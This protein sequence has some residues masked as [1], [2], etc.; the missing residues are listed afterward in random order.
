MA[1]PIE[2][3]R[4][5]CDR[6][7]NSPQAGFKAATHCALAFRATKV[8][9]S[10]RVRI[11]SGL[12]VRGHQ[13]GNPRKCDH[14][15]LQSDDKHHDDGDELTL[16]GEKL[17]RLKASRQTIGQSMCGIR[18][19]RLQSESRWRRATAYWQSVQWMER[20]VVGRLLT[21]SHF[22]SCHSIAHLSGNISGIESRVCSKERVR[23]TGNTLRRAT[24]GSST[25]ARGTSGAAADVWDKRQ[26]RYGAVGYRAKPE[27]APVTAQQSASFDR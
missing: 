21:D 14:G 25:S 9:R 1:V 18:D 23:F 2:R 20:P 4:R 26:R 5:R 3:L 19:S 27:D 22:Q 6:T 7:S 11:G 24:C 10:I 16:H 17:N 12:A 15:T 13:R 8:L